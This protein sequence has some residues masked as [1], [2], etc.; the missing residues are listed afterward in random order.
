VLKSN[1]AACADGLKSALRV[2]G[3]LEVP[4]ELNPSQPNPQLRS[5]RRQFR[6]HR[7]S[8]NVLNYSIEMLGV[9]NDAVVAFS[10]P[11]GAR[12]VQAF[13]DPARGTPLPAL[14]NLLKVTVIVQ[15]PDHSVDVIR[16]HD[17]AAKFVMNTVVIQER[18]DNAIRR[19]PM[20][21]NAPAHPQVK[22]SLDSALDL[23]QQIARRGFHASAAVDFSASNPPSLG[24]V[25]ATSIREVN[26]GAET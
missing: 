17:K 14:Q 18:P 21:Q 26:R 6:Q 7:A 12:I 24:A 2:S 9:T 13:I 25:R 4:A 23:T 10:L 20:P 22:P 8:A 15:G 16:H 5:T 19:F 1:H 11:D 3:R